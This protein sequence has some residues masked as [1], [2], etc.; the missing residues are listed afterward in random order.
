M[1]KH[2]RCCPP[3]PKIEHRPLLDG[4]QARVLADVFKV[5]SN[6]TRLRIIHALIRSEEQCVSELANILSMSPQAVSNQLQRLSGWRILGVR[7]QGNNLYYRVL[8]PCIDQL[9]E[10][11]FCLKEEGFDRQGDVNQDHPTRHRDLH[12]A[13]LIV[14]T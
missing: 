3:K 12:P 6:D 7:R 14:I 10:L 4:E 13:S 1:P 5:L 8:D 9:L 11:G 2:T